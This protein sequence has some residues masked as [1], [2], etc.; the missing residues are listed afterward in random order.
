MRFLLSGHSNAF[1]ENTLLRSD[2]SKEVLTIRQLKSALEEIYFVIN[3]GKEKSKPLDILG[4]DSCQMSMLEIGYEFRK[5]VRYLIG[6]QGETP[7]DGLNYASFLNRFLFDPANQ[8]KM[9]KKFAQD[10]VV[11]YINR[12]RDFDLGG[13]SVDIAAWDLDKSL[14]IIA[15]VEE[16]FKYLDNILDLMNGSK[17]MKMVRN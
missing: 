15:K 9:P 12:Q 13:R 14:N 10:I 5:L 7:N 4:F 1:D 16:L 11:S 17:T 2:N 8:N 3:D 6:S